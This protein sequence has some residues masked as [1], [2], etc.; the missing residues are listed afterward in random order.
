MNNT[1]W[2]G[3]LS[4]T[5]KIDASSTAISFDDCLTE[6][7]DY[8]AIQR[9][10]TDE[11]L[12][13]LSR[14]QTNKMTCAWI[15]EYLR[16]RFPRV[17][18][19]IDENDQL[20][21]RKLY[22]TLQATL[23][24]YDVIQPLMDDE[25]VTEIQINSYDSIWAERKGKLARAVDPLDKSKFL[26]FRSP[27][28]ALYFM[29]NLLQSTNSQMDNGPNKCIGNA[30]T[31]EG[32]RV[33][34]FGPAAMAADKGTAFKAEKSPACVI[35]KFSDNIIRT[36]DL[37]NWFSESDQMA[38][39][40]DLL[41]DNHASV[42]V[43][44]ET[45]A[46][47]TVNLQTVIDGITDNTR[48]ISMEKDSELRL[49]RFDG[50]GVLTN[51]VIQLEYIVEDANRTYTPTTNTAENLFNQNMRFTP[52]TIV[53]GEVRSPKEISLAMTAAEAGHNIMFTVHAGSAYETISRLTTA[54]SKMN[55][56]QMKSDIMNAVCDSLDIVIVP[57]QMKDGSRKVIEIS[58]VVGCHIDDGICVPILNKLYEFRQSGYVNG[59]TYGEHY[60]CNRI[61]DELLE[62][63]SR[64]GMD[65]KVKA[66]LE[67]PVPE[68]GLRGTYNGVRSPYAIPESEV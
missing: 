57:T 25:S 53:F 68:G 50:T 65:P 63:W 21:L 56:G 43:A 28:A 44:G 1:K 37:V 35:R 42:A 55:P 9:A 29:N 6:V 15:D 40:I 46:G 51:N 17:E 18:G 24:G 30:I 27:S 54:M 47:K 58:E 8:I 62:K 34:A 61:S 13:T 66:F 4:T 64:K 60:Q 14:D 3:L 39:F 45:G 22:V 41:G 67:A 32:Y 2:R 7:W 16:T 48:V 10:G 52:R 26:K 59:K 20:E 36:V 5:V 38:T 33:A 11:D 31:P 23:T 12:S 49:R 19:F